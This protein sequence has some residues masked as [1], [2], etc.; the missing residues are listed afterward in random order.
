MVCVLCG[1]EL[2]GKGNNPLPLAHDGRCCDECDDLK[3]TPA[4]LIESGLP[5]DAAKAF[6]KQLREW[7][8]KR[9]AAFNISEEARVSEDPYIKEIIKR[10]EELKAGGKEERQL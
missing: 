6:G 4:R 9:I 8:L 10:Q 7:R 1:I 3:V 5:E 2:P